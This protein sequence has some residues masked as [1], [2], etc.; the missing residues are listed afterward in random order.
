M[1][2]IVKLKSGSFRVQIRRK[3]QYASKTFSN[4]AEALSWSIEAD[5]RSDQG[6][7]ITSPKLTGF[8]TFGQLIDLHIADMIE[9]DKP[10]GRSKDTEQIDLARIALRRL[11]LIGRSN[12]R[13]RRPTQQE[14]DRLVSYFENFAKTE[15]PIARVITVSYTHLTLPTKA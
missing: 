11:G 7:N 8:N 6:W 3:G 14:L 10:L 5:R 4:K 15:I 1:A 2:T 9:V 13:D 12:Q